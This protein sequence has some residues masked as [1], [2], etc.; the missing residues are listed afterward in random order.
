VTGYFERDTSSGEFV[1]IDRSAG[2]IRPLFTQRASLAQVRLE[3]MEPVVIPAR[4]GLKLIG[5][6]TMPAEAQTSARTGLPMVLVIH[7]GPYARDL[8]G[9]Q[10]C[11]SMARE[12]RVRGAERQLPGLD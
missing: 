12:P 6:L 5:Y 8:L 7:G 4:D 10:F 9:L 11:P 2:V 1:L 3:P